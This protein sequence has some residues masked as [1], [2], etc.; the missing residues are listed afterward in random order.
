VPVETVKPGS[1]RSPWAT[2]LRALQSGGASSGAEPVRANRATPATLWGPSPQT[3]S[4]HFCGFVG[5]VPEFG[6][7][8]G[9]GCVHR[10]G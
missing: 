9:A 7:L 4:R 1:H 8:G 6:E 10:G 3:E 2:A 5:T